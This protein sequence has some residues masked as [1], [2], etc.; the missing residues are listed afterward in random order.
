MKALVKH[1]T[2]VNRAMRTGALVCL[3]IFSINAHAQL[4]SPLCP[5]DRSSIWNECFGSS[6]SS[7]GV[8]YEG[9]YRGGKRSGQGTILFPDGAKYVGEW[10]EGQRNGT[11]T[12]TFPDGDT[13]VGEFRDGRFDGEGTYTASKGTKYV[14]GWRVGRRNGI[15]T[16]HFQDGAKFT[17]Q[18]EDNEP[19]GRGLFILADGRRQVGEFRGI[20]LNGEG[21][22]Y[23]AD[24]R[25]IQSGRWRDDKLVESY[26]L[27]QALFPFN[28]VA[29][30]SISGLFSDIAKAIGLTPTETPATPVASTNNRGER[31]TVIENRTCEGNRFEWTGC[32]GKY[33][34]AAGVYE[35]EWKDGLFHGRGSFIYPG[36]SKY[37][38][39]YFQ[40]RRH[41]RGVFTFA[42]GAEYSGDWDNDSRN[43]R[44][45]F[46]GD[47]GRKYVGEFKN[48]AFN[49]HG[50]MTLKNGASYVGAFLNG[51]Y[52]GRGTL[53]LPDGRTWSGEF[54]EG[55][56]QF[57]RANNSEVSS[58]DKSS[59]TSFSQSSTNSRLAVAG[60]EKPDQAA[61]ARPIHASI[62]VALVVGNSNYKINPLENPANDASDIATVL[63]S[64][65]F[66]VMLLTD[67]TLVQM[68]AATR[69]F[70][71]V[72]SRSDVA[73]IFYAGHGI[74]AKGRNYMIPVDA[75]IKREFE[76]EDRAYDS[77]QWLNM[78]NG[79]KGS[80]PQRV[81]IVILDA[82]RD[83]T[84]TRSWRSTSGGLARMDAP[85]GTILVY[86]T[87][88]GKVAADG[89]AGQR[90]SPF[91]KH[92]LQAIQ[93]ANTPIELVLRETR[94]RVVAETKGEQVPWEHSSLVGEFVFRLQR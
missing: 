93:T 61:P 36:G 52:H 31:P 60:S 47:D 24:G 17:G 29:P 62:R 83:N 75:D 19:R 57:S 70:E 10:K 64:L 5:S 25:V 34:S 72:V 22:F 71:E 49:G 38:G 1:L 80:N 84:L 87:A 20:K 67:A 78:L 76:L 65:G 40:G 69:S 13:Y 43:G 28:T 6:S 59:S 85:S 33:S 41:G 68:R 8:K 15:G 90:N 35:G 82:C 7:D 2:I 63:R 48:D 58:G 51:Q 39:Q 81:N 45:T 42:N 3:L 66:D 54:K 92:F 30:L 21:V 79:V 12:F 91:T 14:G 16:L 11:G 37:V 74:E 44:G 32:Y 27:E 53:T 55:A 23:A 77:N 56:A 9:Y 46:F 4:G 18:F 26:P 73:L 86:S 88:P 50:S 94:R 89:A